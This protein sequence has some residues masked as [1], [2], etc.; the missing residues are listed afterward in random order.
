MP[1]LLLSP[2]MHFLAVATTY[3]EA[4]RALIATL[5][6][7]REA[8]GLIS[9]TATLIQVSCPKFYMTVRQ[10]CSGAQAMQASCQTLRELQHVRGP[11]AGVQRADPSL[12]LTRFAFLQSLTLHERPERAALWLPQLPTTL[13]SL[14]MV[15]LPPPREKY[16]FP[17]LENRSASIAGRANSRNGDLSSSL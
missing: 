12:G 10:P 11:G 9:S 3:R 17:Q 1:P 14:T 8:N 2:S 15:A 7:N 6:L 4:G 5:R 13:R 16:L